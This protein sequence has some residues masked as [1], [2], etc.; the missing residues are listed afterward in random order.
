MQVLRKA[1]FVLREYFFPK[2]SFRLGGPDPQR[3]PK[4]LGWEGGLCSARRALS[5]GILHVGNCQAVFEII[6]GKCFPFGAPS[7]YRG[8]NI[9]E[10]FR[11]S[12]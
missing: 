5:N 10:I 8:A 9:P 6:G 1:L 11:D 2:F 4:I 7:P 3:G 12:V